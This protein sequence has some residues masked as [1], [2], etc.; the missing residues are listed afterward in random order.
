[1]KRIL[2]SLLML[3]MLLS[4]LSLNFAVQA[5]TQT[6]SP[7]VY[8]Y[9]DFTKDAD[10]EDF[11]FNST[12]GIP[13]MIED[14]AMKI[15]KD[16]YGV[17][18]GPFMYVV[19]NG[20]MLDFSSETTPPELVL[21]MRIKTHFGSEAG[22]FSSWINNTERAQTF[23]VNKN[24]LFRDHKTT[25]PYYGNYENGQWQTISVVYGNDSTDLTRDVYLNGVKIAT[26][27]GNSYA[28]NNCKFQLAFLPFLSAN[29][30]YIMMDYL[31]IYE[32]QESVIKSRKYYYLLS[33]ISLILLDLNII[34]SREN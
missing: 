17:S 24:G 19:Q 34:T 4:A 16:V 7:E 5:D 10:L 21:E 9:N 29:G 30:Q 26:F 2:S 3:T 22:Y 23:G 11:T 18:V 6:T 8:Y 32:K 20:N 27:D 1:M 15:T 14:G 28:Q 31:K 25:T 13:P 33:L 12:N